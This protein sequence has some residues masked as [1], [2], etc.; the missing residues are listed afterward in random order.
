MV[1]M[2]VGYRRIKE[3]EAAIEAG[4]LMVLADVPPENGLK[5]SKPA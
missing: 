3:F 2:N 1:G 5:K 4:E